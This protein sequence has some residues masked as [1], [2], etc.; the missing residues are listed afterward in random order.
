MAG[1]VSQLKSLVMSAVARGDLKVGD[2]LPSEREMIRQFGVS[3]AA[4]REGLSPLVDEGILERRRGAG[5]FIARLEPEPQTRIFAVMVPCANS[6]QENVYHQL[7]RPIEDAL[8]ERSSS[9]VL[10]NHDNDLE[11]IRRYVLRLCQDRVSGVIFAPMIISGCAEANLAA[12]R[13]FERAGIPF[14]LIDCA[15]SDETLPRF[16]LVA[17]NDFAAAREIVRHLVALGHRRIAFIRGL[18]GVFST[19]QRYL[20]FLEEMQIQDLAVPPEYAK[21]TAEEPLSEQGRRELRELLAA[22]APP[23]AVICPHDVVAKNVIEE[24]H[25]AGLRVG[26]DLGVVGFDDVPFAAHLDPP[27]TTVRQPTDEEGRLAVE[28]LF[29]K[30]DGTMEGERQEFLACELIV[31]NSC[32]AGVARPAPSSTA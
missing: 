14:V 20:G 11:K 9:L 12:L 21:Q 6:V 29:D 31:R 10:C 19:D 27:L 32:G 4:I 22:E 5:T 25:S 18:A 8:H 7:L 16:T 2:K 23:T 26:A 30:L 3:R 17:A 13:E 28:L 1:R 15:V 24:A